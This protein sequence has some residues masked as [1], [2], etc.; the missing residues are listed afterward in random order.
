MKNKLITLCFFLAVSVMIFAQEKR[1]K[2][3][4]VGNSITF[5]AGIK[6][7]DK[8]SYPAVLGQML[9][10]RYEVR[11]YGFSARTLLNKGDNPYMKEKMF[12]D[13]QEFLPDIVIIKLGTNDSKPHNWKYGHEYPRDLQ[14]MVNILRRL[15]SVPEIYLCYPP[16][17][18]PPH[19]G[20][21][22]SIIVNGVIPYIGQ[23]AKK[24]KLKTIDLHTATD[25]MEQNFPDKIHPNEKGAVIIA[26][27]VYEAITGEKKQY[28]S[29]DFPGVKS[30]WNG[31]DRYDFLYKGREV[32]AVVP[33]KPAEGNPW[34]WRPAFFGA[35]PSVD[36]ALLDKGFHVV[37]YD[38]T[39]LYGSP[40]AVKMGNDFYRYMTDYYNVSK[41]VTLEGFSRGGLFVFNWAAVNTDKV[42]CIYV[43]APVCNVL[44]WPG[45]KNKELWKDMLGHWK[46][47]DEEMN[48]F[49]GNPV[50]KAPGIAK[51]GIPVIAVCGDSDKT[52]PYRE[53]MEIMRDILVREGSP[54]EVILKAGVDHHPHSLE[55]P[56]PVV[57]F[58][59]RNQ[60]DYI[61]YQ[62]INV[63]GTLKNSFLKFENKRKG[64]VAFLGGSITR[65][66]GWS[67]LVATQLK[68]RFPYT[69][70]EFINAGIPST[71]STPGAFRIKE[72]VLNRGPIDL[73]FVEAAVNDDTNGF[74]YI[75]QVRGMEGEVRRAL[76]ENPYTDIVM[77][78]F[79]YDPF[80]TSMAG[81]RVPDVVY[82]HERVAN[83]YQIPSV[84][85][86]S[87]VT[88]RMNKGEFSWEE[89]GGTHPAPLGHSFYTATIAR[90][91][92]KMWHGV[93][94]TEVATPH[95]IP[96]RPLDRYSYYGG[97]LIDIKEAKLSSGWNYVASWRPNDSAGK[98]EGFVDV[99][100]LET[101]KAG[102]KLSLTFEGKAVGIF[103]VCGP[104]AGI[105]EYSID[106]MPYK[107]LDT[108]TPWSKGL[109]LPWVYM[110]E[111]ELEPGKHVLKMRMTR[112]KNSESAGHELQ[113]RNFV[114]NF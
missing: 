63:R 19:R 30:D 83:H 26:E 51:A 59:V 55:D 37:Y 94:L 89:F 10:S 46:L 7:R 35:F 113:I 69:E 76:L 65:M 6:N 53:N 91:F 108:F 4:C 105:I 110:L 32:I 38:L 97:E 21:N 11:N 18:Y 78:H 77:L 101:R 40:D 109:Y 85:L 100:M 25:G 2:V 92:D 54:V 23:I 82:N 64:K 42:A 52:V 99:P 57:D 5:G 70:F 114:V 50:N 31:F 80:I 36:I 67:N 106:G 102:S 66:D 93:A 8:D 61:K 34:I 1:V 14:T 107:E 49:G 68:Q 39:H 48:N 13:V 17:V 88:A 47:T 58:I 103:C 87:E 95:D 72:D 104:S 96:A 98:R 90:L 86:I 81:G 15:P 43:D 74:D 45:R 33:G 29:Q 41:K 16:K 44:S 79:I 9:G 112:N 73:L 12:R 75:E 84:N 3:A 22:D 20:I 60:P 56:K 27:T 24:N 111:T 71:G 62:D 28:E